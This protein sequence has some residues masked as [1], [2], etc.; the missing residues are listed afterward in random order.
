M[1]EVVPKFDA[2]SITELLLELYGMEGELSPLVSYEDQNALVR[3]TEGTFV[4]KIANTK[5]PIAF[6]QMQTDVLGY[7]KTSVPELTFPT[8]VPTLNGETV[9]RVDGFAV[10]LLTY[11]EGELLVNSPRS[12]ELYEDIG[13]YLGKYAETMLAYPHAV[14]DGS[15]V[16]WKLDNVIACKPYLSNVTDEDA[17]DRIERLYPVYEAAILPRLPQLRKGLI[18]GDANEQ[19]FLVDPRHPDVVAGLIDFGEMQLSSQINELAI[20]LAYCLFGE[21]D[22]EMASSKMIEGYERVFPITEEE[23]EIIYYLMAMRLVTSIT[24]SSYSFKLHP[25]NEYLLVAQKPGIE[26]LKRLEDEN[27]ISMRPRL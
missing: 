14:C 11:L 15:D 10:R 5:W 18:H 4:L 9:S 17:R 20:A 6:V 24:M 3:T 25:E 12:P 1:Q 26:L 7:L 2:Q 22:I 19:N 8:V 21:D 13:R 27:Y 23:R 16:L